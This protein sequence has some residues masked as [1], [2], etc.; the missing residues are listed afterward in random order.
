M[1][2]ELVIEDAP[3]LERLIPFGAHAGP[4]TIRVLAAPKLTV[5]GYLSWNISEIVLGTII[6]KVEQVFFL[7]QLGQFCLHCG[8][9]FFDV[10]TSVFVCFSRKGSPSRSPRRCTQ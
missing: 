4:R 6:I 8:L 2:K 9:L 1:F 5:L 7:L 10:F 3:C